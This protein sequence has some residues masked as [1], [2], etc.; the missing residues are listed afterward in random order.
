MKSRVADRIN[1]RLVDTQKE[2]DKVRMQAK[3]GEREIEKTISLVHHDEFEILMDGASDD[4]SSSKRYKFIND[5]DVLR[6]DQNE[7][8]KQEARLKD[9]RSR[10]ASLEKEIERLRFWRDRADT[11]DVIRQ[12]D[13]EKHIFG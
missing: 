2:L 12:M 3:E 13:A 8:H 11:E 1:A 6:K 7:R 5:L 10:I 4:D 9:M